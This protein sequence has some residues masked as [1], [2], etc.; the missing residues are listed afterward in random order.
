MPDGLA[1][2][3]PAV[4]TLPAGREVEEYFPPGDKELNVY[5][6]IPERRLQAANVAVESV[7]SPDA[8]TRYT[9]E[10]R[11]V[12]DFNTGAEEKAIQVARKNFRVLFGGEHRDGFSCL[13]IAQVVR[14]VAGA[15]V[16]KPTHIAPC[17]NIAHNS[18]LMGLL[19]RQIE[20]LAT[21]SASISTMRR[22]RG[23]GLADFTASEVAN[24]WLLHTINTYIPE[25]RHIWKVRHGHPEPAYLV[26]A[27]LAGALST[28]SLTVRPEDLPDYDH[29]DLGSCFVAL[30]EQIRLLV[31]T[32]IAEGYLAV[33]LT[34][35]EQ[36]IWRG[37]VPEDHYFEDAQFFLSISSAM[38]AGDLIQK[39]PLRVKAAAVDEISRVIE[40]ALAGISLTH[41]PS[42][43]AIRMKLGNQYFAMGQSGDLWQKVRQSR[44]IAVF[45]PPDITE[46]N[47]ELIVVKKDVKGAGKRS[48]PA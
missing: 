40:R 15:Y 25:L 16:L 7:Q 46:P 8:G 13:R 44:S 4:D 31:D 36:N 33:P 32:V 47:L 24:L 19:R 30:D 2:R 26:L 37:T 38:D 1:F 18:Y 20:V 12:A 9:A 6:A 41:A 21:K 29:D 5:L 17:L 10:T 22:E 45:T 28:F 27:R 43:P 35:D 3:M 23:K 34:P 39:V 48:R 14:N 11:T 42:P